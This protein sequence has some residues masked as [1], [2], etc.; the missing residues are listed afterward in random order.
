MYVRITHFYHPVRSSV[1]ITSGKKKSSL[2]SD[3]NRL[4]LPK[5]TG[6]IF[7]LAYVYVLFADGLLPRLNFWPGRSICGLR[8]PFP[9]LE[10]RE[11]NSQNENTISGE[12]NLNYEH[13]K[14]TGKIRKNT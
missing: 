8:F 1:F 3:D 6:D 14:K 2:C 12:H 11:T 7:R 13:Q 4:P 5:D 9:F 10:S